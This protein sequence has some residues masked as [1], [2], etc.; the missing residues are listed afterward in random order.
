MKC[1]RNATFPGRLPKIVFNYFLFTDLFHVPKVLT[2]SMP[3]INIGLVGFK[4]GVP[5]DFEF[6]ETKTNHST[7][8]P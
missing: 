7:I 2:T 3:S 1:H 4:K 6:G 8:T 5:F